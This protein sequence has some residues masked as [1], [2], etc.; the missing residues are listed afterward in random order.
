MAALFTEEM[1]GPEEDPRLET[2]PRAGLEVLRGANSQASVMHLRSSE[3]DL[4]IFLHVSGDQ[5]HRY[6]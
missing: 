6:R 4:E 3:G 1:K 5:R 2:R